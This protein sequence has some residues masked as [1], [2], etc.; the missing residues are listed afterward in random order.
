[1]GTVM[2]LSLSRSTYPRSGTDGDLQKSLYKFLTPGD[3]F[4]LQIPY[5][6]YRDPKNNEIFGQ[7]PHPL[8]QIMLKNRYKSPPITQRRVGGDWQW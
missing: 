5:K 3:D 2:C 8:G 1:M 7:M 6:L 4:M